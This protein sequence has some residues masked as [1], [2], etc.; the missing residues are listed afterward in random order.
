MTA[1]FLAH[2]PL[3]EAA[4]RYPDNEAVVFGEER[5]T[6]RTLDQLSNGLANTLLDQGLQK[7]DRVVLCLRKSIASFIGMYG[8]LKS[9][10]CYVPVD[11]RAPPARCG[12]I[13]CDSRAAFLLTTSGLLENVRAELRESDLRS[14]VLFDDAATTAQPLKNGAEPILGDLSI[15]SFKGTPQDLRSLPNNLQ[16]IENDTACIYYT[17]GSTGTPKGVMRSHRSMRASAESIVDFEG[18]VHSDRVA[19]QFPLHFAASSPSIFGS[20]IAGST[21]VFA[22]ESNALFPGHLAKLVESERASVLNSVPS[23]LILMILY[24]NPEAHDLSHLRV[25]AFGGEAFPPKHL[26]RLMA[27]IPDARFIN[28]LG[29]TEMPLTSIYEVKSID[30]G[31]VSPMPIGKAPKNVEIFAIDGDG[32]MIEKPGE[33]GELY[34]RGPMIMQGY[35]GDPERTARSLVKNPL[36]PDLEEKVV[37][38]GDM[39]TLDRGGNYILLGREDQMVKSRGNRVDLG[40]VEATMYAHP[41]VKEVAVVPI[42]DD[43][44]GNRIVAFVS[45]QDGSS[46][47]R[48]DLLAHCAQ[49]LPRYMVPTSIELR[50]SLPRNPNGKVDKVSLIKE[51]VAREKGSAI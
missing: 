49:R 25:I 29:S 21:L 43:L 11:P 42:P 2:H 35:W 33:K 37:K 36:R 7:G 24:G 28:V 14:V 30:S 6:Y 13:V 27:L 39:V 18:F 44:I 48:E 12:Q 47:K 22:P 23:A 15:V 34:V 9:G 46:A 20:C 50:D 5:I 8:A 26:S 1:V 19:C 17:S 10:G 41:A 4:Q 16:A 38:T 40:E 45:L 32:R 31:Q 3:Q 51:E